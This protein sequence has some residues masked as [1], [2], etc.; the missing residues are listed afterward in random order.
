[1]K[2]LPSKAGWT[3]QLGFYKH[4]SALTSPLSF[5]HSFPFDAVALFISI[6]SYV[7]CI[8]ENA[9]HSF[10]NKVGHILTNKSSK[11]LKDLSETQER[12]AGEINQCAHSLK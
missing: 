6:L 5:N 10:W 11:K 12:N 2:R 7:V 1:M 3:S 9:L 8:F 4:A